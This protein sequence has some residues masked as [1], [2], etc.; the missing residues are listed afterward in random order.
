VD[1]DE[2]EHWFKKGD[3]VVKDGRRGTVAWIGTT[4]GNLRSLG[5][6]FDCEAGVNRL[7]ADHVQPLDAISKLAELTWLREG[8][9]VRLKADHQIHGYVARVSGMNQTARVVWAVL[10]GE[11]LLLSLL[12]KFYAREE[13][14]PISRLERVL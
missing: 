14:V 1:D 5:V 2:D 10:P 3:R 4:I 6:R 8:D 7:E 9:H 12:T 13:W 11:A